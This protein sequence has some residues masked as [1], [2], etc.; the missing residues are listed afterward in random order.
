MR[1]NTAVTG[2][3]GGV[4]K[5]DGMSVTQRPFTGSS[6]GTQV[7]SKPYK[8]TVVPDDESADCTSA[9]D[10]ALVPCG[11]PTIERVG[12]VIR[13]PLDHGSPHRLF[14]FMWLRAP[15]SMCRAANERFLAVPSALL[16]E[17]PLFRTL[18]SRKKGENPRR[19]M[20]VAADDFVESSEEFVSSMESLDEPVDFF[21]LGKGLAAI[22]GDVSLK[23][24]VAC[25]EDLLEEP[26]ATFLADE[27]TEGLEGRLWQSLFAVALMPASDARLR[28]AYVG[29]LR[30]LSFL[31][32]LQAEQLAQEVPGC[33]LTKEACRRQAIEATP[34]LPDGVVPPPV[35]LGVQS[36]GIGDLKIVRRC[37][38]G[39][40]LGE[41]AR[42]TNVMSRERLELTDREL[43]CVSESLRDT[44]QTD[45]DGE[46]GDQNMT[47][48][49]LLTE[50]HDLIR[51]DRLCS[52]Y[53]NLTQQYGAQNAGGTDGS[54][55]SVTL[56][57]SW[58]GQEGIK[59]R[60]DDE[61]QEY[62]QA[63]IQR[64]VVRI[65]E[66]VTASRSRLTHHEHEK[67]TNHDVDNRQGDDALIGI[68]RWLQKRYRLYAEDAGK[69]LIVELWIANPAETFLE[70]IERRL[71]GPTGPPPTLAGEG[72]YGPEFINPE[73]YRYLASLFGVVEAEEPPSNVLQLATDFRSQSPVH[74]TQ[75]EIPAGYAVTDA[76]VSYLLSDERS[77]LVGYVGEE[78]FSIAGSAPE[79]G[80]EGNAGPGEGDTGTDDPSSCPPLADPVAVG[81][82]TGSPTVGTET[83]SSV[84][85]NGSALPIGVFS[86]AVS[87]QVTVQVE[88]VL[89]GGLLEA[90]QARTYEA[91][92]AAQGRAQGTFDDG[93]ANRLATECDG[94]ERS[95]ERRELQR[96]G[97]HLL[98]QL[99]RASVPLASPSSASPCSERSS[100]LLFS[101]FFE[102]AFE[103]ADMTYA[104]H[105]WPMNTPTC[106]RDTYWRGQELAAL[107][108]EDAL[109]KSFLDAKTARVLVP[110][111]PGR[112]LSVLHF[113]DYGR[114]WSTPASDTPV[115]QQDLP[116][117]ADALKQPEAPCESL[118]DAS[119]S[120][121]V[122]VPTSMVI[123]QQGDAL[124]ELSC[125]LEL[126]ASRQEEVQ[127]PVTGG[128]VGDLRIS[129]P[130]VSQP[131]SVA[132]TSSR[133]MPGQTASA[134][135]GSSEQVEAVTS[136]VTRIG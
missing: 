103:W 73:N 108:D 37:L 128:A 91:L 78:T 121:E 33:S 43:D 2:S 26:L 81:E 67:L 133:P 87:Y 131:L 114:L 82:C 35:C 59:E 123:L 79:T 25:V 80:A 55:P 56:N 129:G 89:E 96:H 24:L 16:Q 95:V 8:R 45:R 11:K 105:A 12:A 19:E 61:A 99:H 111:R 69:R 7:V 120:W 48:S 126:P 9:N 51:T 54:S 15:D 101:Q 46:S 132:S 74:S 57:G 130:V 118:P 127:A 64:A 115:A 47:R 76:Q 134:E 3:R 36:L 109:F 70:R 38:Q 117:V 22:E 44:T 75:L 32:R 85:M 86:D 28:A 49:A 71:D 4:R 92:A 58:S 90:W 66:A 112:E 21:Q 100:D 93:M 53:N 68:Y 20:M 124:P 10:G 83:L 40:A 98:W 50:V 65:R 6:L 30:I 17:L 135:A 60:A 52:Q 94:Q 119:R 23:A 13:N 72:V 18:A 113:L 116:L 34:I 27:R 5:Q 122:E 136:G 102:S 106:R 1:T 31:Q 63:L 77:S 29:V 97:T 41:V 42:I 39:Y 110:V 62:A 84:Q 88:A 14:E 107:C 104:F 125:P